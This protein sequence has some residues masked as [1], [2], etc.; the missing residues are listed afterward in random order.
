MVTRMHHD[1]RQWN[2]TPTCSNRRS[3]FSTNLQRGRERSQTWTTQPS[4]N[5]TTDCCV[6]P[7]PFSSRTRT[8]QTSSISTRV[9]DDWSG[10]ESES[11]S[12]T[13]EISVVLANV[14]QKG[15]A[16]NRFLGITSRERNCWIYVQRDACQRARV[17]QIEA[18]ICS[19]RVSQLGFCCDSV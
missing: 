5:E 4:S 3:G 11:N 18:Q 16:T 9:F 10:L 1:L 15:P 13:K 6:K 2:R 19:A 7:M 17:G 12:V 14:D 8:R